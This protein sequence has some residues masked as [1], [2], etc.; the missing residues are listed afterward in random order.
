MATQYASITDLQS[1]L[2]DEAT[3]TG[4]GITDA[5]KNAALLAASEEADSYFR[6]RFTVPLGGY[7]Q[8]V[9]QAVCEIAVF[10]L[11][12]KKGYTAQG[13]DKTLVDGYTRAVAW[14]TK[15]SK[16]VVTPDGTDSSTPSGIVAQI[17]SSDER[18]W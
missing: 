12:T 8:D 18:G 1:L 15:V 9:K 16:G 7:G 2:I 5:E 13:G 3:L 14:L 4:M 17:F 6:S 11:M 10:R